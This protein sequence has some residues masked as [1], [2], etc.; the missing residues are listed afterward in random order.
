[1][2]KYVDL[3]LAKKKRIHF[4][5]FILSRGFSLIFLFYLIVY[6][7]ELSEY[8]FTRPKTLLHTSFCLF[9]KSSKAFSFSVMLLQQNN[10]HKEYRYQI[11]KEIRNL[12][13]NFPNL[14]MLSYFFQIETKFGHQKKLHKKRNQANQSLCK[15]LIRIT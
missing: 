1:M 7:I 8:I 3:G 2:K 5:T 4:L 6:C 14:L 15:I 12:E 10:C 13:L 11:F 9:S